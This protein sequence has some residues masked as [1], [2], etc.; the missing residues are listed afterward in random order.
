MTKIK[1]PETKE[2]IEYNKIALER[3]KVK[4]ADKHEVKSTSKINKV[5]NNCRNL[6]GSIY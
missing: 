3:I 5:L 1:Y 6:R 2:I 4:K